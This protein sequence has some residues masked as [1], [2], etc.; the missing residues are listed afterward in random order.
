MKDNT[1]ERPIPQSGSAQPTRQTRF[2]GPDK[3]P[4]KRRTDNPAR[5]LP[6]SIEARRIAEARGKRVGR[7]AGSRNGVSRAERAIDAALA[8]AK[9]KLELAFVEAVGAWPTPGQRRELYRS[10]DPEL[11]RAWSRVLERREERRAAGV[12]TAPSV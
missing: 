8:S 10:I 3:K 9:A 12:V 4:R 7:P 2:R 5:Y 11:V 6:S 1:T